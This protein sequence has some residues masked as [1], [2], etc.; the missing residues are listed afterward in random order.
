MFLFLAGFIGSAVF[1]LSS[2]S[3]AA[4]HGGGFRGGG[5]RGG[6]FQGRAFT[7][8]HGFRRGHPH[9]VRQFVWPGYWYTYYWPDYYPLDYSLLDSDS[10]YTV[11][12]SAPA[13]P[14]YYAH[15]TTTPPV[16]VVINQPNPRST[17]SSNAGYANGNYRATTAEGQESIVA[18]R[19]NEQL[20]VGANAF[21]PVSPATQSAPAAVQATQAVPQVRAAGSDKFVLVSWLNDGGKDIIYVQNTETNEVQRITSEPNIDNF[22]IVQVHPNADPK[23]FEAIIS[24]GSV[25]TP[26]RFHF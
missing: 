23:E 24:N 5:F 22:R 13:T 26:V 20:G 3:H 17:D 6:G 21:K 10:D 14:E 19:S 15:D 11:S 25:Q 2:T 16:V 12:S 18:Q 1:A 7:T 9:F 4:P 8:G